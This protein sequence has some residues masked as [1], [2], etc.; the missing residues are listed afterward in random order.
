MQRSAVR[1]RNAGFTLLEAMIAMLLMSIILAAMATV[2][3]QWLPNW[4]RGFARL[5]RDQLSAL[6]LERLTDDLADAQFISADPKDKTP[7]FDGSELSVIFVRSILAPNFATGLEVVQIAAVSNDFGSALVR[8]TAPIPIGLAQSDGTELVFTNPVVVMRGPYHFSFSYAGSDRV[9]RDN[10][11]NGAQLPRAVRVSLRD[12]AT[13]MTLTAS[14]STSIHAELPARCTWAQTS[15]DCPELEGQKIWRENHGVGLA[16]SA[17]STVAGAPG[18][19]GTAGSQASSAASAAPPALGSSAV[20]TP[21][22]G[23][24]V[25][26]TPT[27]AANAQPLSPSGE[28]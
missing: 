17:A 5:Q 10:W 7:L 1:P 19:A 6:G 24:T 11:H 28:K 13:S 12:N 9:W 20:S 8:S 23:P 25:A 3:A 16:G 14:T 27:P 22:A 26:P 21:K 15:S 18:A 2:T 4:N